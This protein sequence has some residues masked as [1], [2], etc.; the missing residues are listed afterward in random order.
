M[1]DRNEK[2]PEVLPVAGFR[3]GTTRAG[4]KYPD[5]RDLVVMAMDAGSSFWDE[6]AVEAEC[7]APVTVARKHLSG[8]SPRLLLVNSGNC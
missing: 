6:I 7:A 4:I 8:N 2:I 5:R 1:T 3:L